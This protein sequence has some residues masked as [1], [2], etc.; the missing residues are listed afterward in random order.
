MPC[1]RQ[2]GF[3]FRGP[4]FAAR[5]L[6]LIRFPL[7]EIPSSGLDSSFTLLSIAS[8]LYQVMACFVIGGILTVILIKMLER[9][10]Y[11]NNEEQGE[12]RIVIP[13]QEVGDGEREVERVVP[14]LTMKMNYNESFHKNK[15]NFKVLLRTII[16]CYFIINIFFF[17]K[18][19]A[20]WR[21]SDQSC[22]IRQSYL[23]SIVT[24]HSVF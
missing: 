19:L 3:T 23:H 1:E 4:L 14:A 22:R 16:V 20:L 8:S 9:Q 18:T 15:M 10:R 5:A 2:R 6:W 7:N 21:Q 11:Q 17:L 24:F 13:V 12:R